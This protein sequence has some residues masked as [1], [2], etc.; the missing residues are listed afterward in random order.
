MVVRPRGK[1]FH[2]KEGRDGPS[3]RAHR[4]YCGSEETEQEAWKQSPTAATHLK[5][6][7]QEGTV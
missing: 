3:R 1:I 5:M 6:K 7:D 2:E 4:Q